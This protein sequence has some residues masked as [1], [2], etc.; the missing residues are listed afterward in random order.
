MRPAQLCEQVPRV[1]NRLALL[2]NDAGLTG[3]YLDDLL[4]PR[5]RGGRQGFALEVSDE[6]AALQLFN[7]DR[8][9]DDGDSGAD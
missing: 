2:W 1:A 6:L 7:D 4:Q 5:R 9:Y 8:L 3:H